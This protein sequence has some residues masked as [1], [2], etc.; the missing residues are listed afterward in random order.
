MYNIIYNK[1]CAIYH[2]YYIIYIY[3][4]LICNVLYIMHHISYIIYHIWSCIIIYHISY[5]K[6]MIWYIHMIIF[7]YIFIYIYT[8]MTC[9]YSCCWKIKF[10]CMSTNSCSYAAC[11]W[12]SSC[13]CVHLHI[14]ILYIYIL[15]YILWVCGVYIY[16]LCIIYCVTPVSFFITPSSWGWVPLCFS[17]LAWLQHADSCRL[18]SKR[19]T[20]PGHRFCPRCVK[21][22]KHYNG[23]TYT[24]NIGIHWNRHVKTI[25]LCTEKTCTS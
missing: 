15:C 25:H 7:V 10:L 9:G 21:E 5:S 20:T 18:G 23:S 16:I 13:G 11:L 12:K 6:Y 17:Q 2:I 22:K 3:I 8:Y 14:Y 4:Y 19:K 1:S 24:F